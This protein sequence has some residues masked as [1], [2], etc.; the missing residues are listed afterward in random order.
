[1]C[2]KHKMMFDWLAGDA[3]LYGNTIDVFT[4]VETL[5]RLGVSGR[6]IHVIHPP[7]DNPT[8]CFPNGSV[9]LA[10]KQALDKEEVHV[11]HDFLLTHIN[12]GRRTDPVTSVTFTT[13]AQTL[14]LECA[15]SETT[16]RGTEN[17]LKHHCTNFKEPYYTFCIS[18]YFYIMF[19]VSK[20]HF[21]SKR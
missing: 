21:H 10:V 9:E 3:V 2:T 6:R 16:C 15:V 13:D 17:I 12:D 20:T 8:S 19:F 11:H 1:M 18:I 14:R 7:E 4:C 5:M